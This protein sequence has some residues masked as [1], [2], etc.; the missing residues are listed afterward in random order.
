MTK[1]N[2][3]GEIVRGA[4][5]KRSWD[6]LDGMPRAARAAIWDGMVPWS[7]KEV[8]KVARYKGVCGAIKAILASDRIFRSE[9]GETPHIRAGATQLRSFAHM[10]L[11][12]EPST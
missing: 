2:H 7:P 8:A 12:K 3:S 9:P 6:I 5:A 4:E 11:R 10:Y 1:H